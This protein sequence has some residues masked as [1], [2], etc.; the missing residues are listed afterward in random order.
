[1]SKIGKW[2]RATGSTPDHAHKTVSESRCAQEL[3]EHPFLW[4]AGPCGRWARLPW[5]PCLQPLRL[6]G[7][8]CGWVTPRVTTDAQNRYRERQFGDS[9][10]CETQDQCSTWGAGCRRPCRLPH[11]A[12]RSVIGRIHITGG[13]RWRP[14]RAASSGVRRSCRLFSSTIFFDGICSRS[15]R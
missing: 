3:E 9:D 13:G 12:A 8:L 2:R 6:E 14:V 7:R 4:A 11:R 1:M 15:A 5:R 10:R